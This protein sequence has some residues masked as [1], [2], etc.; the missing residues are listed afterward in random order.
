MGSK[1]TKNSFTGGCL[2]LTQPGGA[3]S[4]PAD[5][6]AYHAGFPLTGPVTFS[7]AD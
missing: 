5:A 7:A 4:A 3:Y 1:Y 2:P 6:L